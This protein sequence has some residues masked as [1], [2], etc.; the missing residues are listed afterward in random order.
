MFE[1]YLY[2][3]NLHWQDIKY[4]AGTEREL[5]KTIMPLMEVDQ[6]IAISGIRRCGKSYLLKQITNQLLVS[7]VLP[8]NILFVNLELPEFAGEAASEV[9]GEVIKI[10]RKL[11]NPSGKV[12]LL[13]DEVQT[14]QKW[15]VWIKYN[16]D[17]YKGDIKFVITGSN[18]HLLSSEFATLLSGRVV[19]KTI[20]PFSFREMLHYY[21]INFQ[22]AQNRSIN[23]DEISHYFETFL[24]DGAMPE[25]FKTVQ[26]DLKRELLSSY[27]NTI[28]YKDI[29]PRFSIRETTLIKDLSLYL[30]GQITSIVNINKLSEYFHSNRKTIRE[31]I[32]YCEQA[33]LI[34]IVK[35]FDFSQKRQQLSL[36]KCFAIDNGFSN[37]VAFR[38]SQNKGK[39]LE[40]VVFVE[41]KRRYG[42]IYYQHNNAECDFIV[43]D[44]MREKL[45]VQVCY[46]LNINNKDREIKGLIAGCKLIEA[47]EG[48]LLTY[49]Q[50]DRFIIEGIEIKIIPVCEWLLQEP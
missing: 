25:I 31:F 22:D 14:L 42:N 49:D 21:G 37:L 24:N 8:E 5:L 40:N 16:Y 27:F 33:F 48:L 18:S 32:N 7:G 3:Q 46:E 45:A 10:Y 26:Q 28:I 13:L 17:L 47:R 15:E 39:L 44:M 20:Y 50:N 30:L 41:L 9:L 29:V 43:Y 6:I 4:E 1:K 19:E 2:E 35:K 11:K 34:N 38:F 12:F 23:R 36:K